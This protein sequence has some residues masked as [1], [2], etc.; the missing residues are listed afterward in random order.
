MCL[1]RDGNYEICSRWV[2]RFTVR[3]V[4]HFL[5]VGFMCLSKVGFESRMLIQVWCMVYLHMVLLGFGL[6]KVVFQDFA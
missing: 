5:T 3:Y 1:L 4:V 6:V 2:A